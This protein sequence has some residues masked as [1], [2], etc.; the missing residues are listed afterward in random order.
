M[1]ERTINLG[2][3]AGRI[4]HLAVDLSHKRLFVSELGADSVA[5]VDLQSGQVIRRIDGLHEPQGIGLSP[6]TGVL[7]IA[8]AGDGKLRLFRADD[9]APSGA[10]ALGDDADNIRP[11]GS[12]RLMVGYGSGGLATIDTSTG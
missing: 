3:V 7:A 12:G 10:V 6:G 5:V 9:L 1:L 8:S 11:D 2:K 4:D